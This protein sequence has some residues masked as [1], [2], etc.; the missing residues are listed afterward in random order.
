MSFRIRPAQL[1]DLPSIEALYRDHA[2]RAETGAHQGNV[3]RRQFAS[4]RLW[5]LLNNTFAAILPITSSA[6]YLYVQEGQ[7]GIDGFVQAQAAPAGRHVWQVINLCLKAG[8]DS[9][10][11]G[12]ALL[13]HL[14]NEGLNRGVVRFTVRLP[15]DD[16]A[17]ELFM[18][19]G[20]LPYATEHGLLSEAVSPRPAPD[21][22][23]WHLRLSPHTRYPSCLC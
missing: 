23:G 7:K 5:F 11:A 1:K 2:E 3:L 9:F 10:Q 8:S 20:F 21:L 12:T 14:T 15:I 16:P 6:D 17:T 22:T 19:R 4:R 13:D 18:A